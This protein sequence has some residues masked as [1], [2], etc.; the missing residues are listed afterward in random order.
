MKMEPLSARDSDG[1][2]RVEQELLAQIRA[3][4]EVYLEAAEEYARISRKYRKTVGDPDSA[5]ALRKAAT[6]EQIAFEKYNGALDS[7]T[8]LI[9]RSC[10]A[11]SVNDAEN[12]ADPS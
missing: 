6:N 7:L 11:V 10:P 5:V 3:A 4:G 1:R 2:D 8:K 12:V 9:L